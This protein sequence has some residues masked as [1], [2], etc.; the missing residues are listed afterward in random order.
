VIVGR[1]LTSNIHVR[2]IVTIVEMGEETISDTSREI[3]RVTSVGVAA[4][5]SKKRIQ[6]LVADESKR[7][8]KKD[9]ELT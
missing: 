8:R 4:V 1:K 6:H 2:N 7:K 3:E 9:V 5:T